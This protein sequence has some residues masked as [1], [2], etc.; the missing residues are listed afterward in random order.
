MKR[1]TLIEHKET[2]I[3]CEENGLVSL[4]YNV[5]LTTPKINTIIKPIVPVVTVKLILPCINCGKTNHSIE[6]YHNRKREVLV[7][8]IAIVKSTKLV[9]RTKTQHVKS[10]KI[11]VHYPFIICSNVEHRSR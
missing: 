1:N 11:H 9:A 3:V 2:V 5:L 10:R 4:N 8:L 7:V 6:T